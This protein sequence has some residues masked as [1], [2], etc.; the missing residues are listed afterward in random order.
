MLQ[1]KQWLMF[2]CLILVASLSS[3]NELI[4]EASE[5][6][7]TGKQMG[8]EFQGKIESYSAQAVFSSQGQLE[9]LELEIRADSLFTKNSERDQL[10]HSNEWL[11]AAQYP[12]M[13]FTGTSQDGLE[14]HGQ[15]TIRDTSLPLV[16]SLRYENEAGLRSVSATGEINRLDYGLGSGEWL[17]TAVVGAEVGFAATLS[18][19]P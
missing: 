7:F 2:S 9:Q 3:A 10:L 17:D 16:L 6:G 19:K 12:V 18:F 15:L 14:I 4:A 8:R 11:D 13:R 1:L 5:I